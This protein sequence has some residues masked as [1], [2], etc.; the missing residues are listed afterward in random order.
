MQTTDQD[1][2]FLSD[3]PMG[4]K[5][6]SGKGR[7]D[8]KYGHQEY[9][10]DFFRGAYQD[11]VSALQNPQLGDDFCYPSDEAFVWYFPEF[12]FVKAMRGNSLRKWD[13]TIKDYPSFKHYYHMIYVQREH[14]MHKIL[15]LEVMVPEQIKKELFHGPQHTV[16]DLGQRLQQLEGHFGGQE[17]Q[18]KQIGNDLQK[19]QA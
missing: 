7:K 18:M 6:R 11:K 1:L 5:A 19:L 10:L 15:A 14:Y 3:W 17:K 16:E 9:D 13:G 8:K 4:R 12:D 2:S